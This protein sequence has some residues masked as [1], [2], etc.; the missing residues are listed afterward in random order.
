MIDICIGLPI[1]VGL[2]SPFC[3]YVEVQIPCH[4]P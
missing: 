4:L 3:G 2:A 1:R